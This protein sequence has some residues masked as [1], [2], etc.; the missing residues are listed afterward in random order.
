MRKL[1]GW[2]LAAAVMLATGAQAQEAQVLAV[3]P[4]PP[5]GAY[6]L[7]LTHGRLIFKVSHLG[8]SNYTAFFRDFSADLAFDPANPAAMSVA[9]R[10]ISAAFR[11]E[12]MSRMASA[13]VMKNSRTFSG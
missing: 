9:R 4:N 10:A 8:F 12:R 6:T 2:V 1:R 13:P 7:D 11:Q 3:D 5:A